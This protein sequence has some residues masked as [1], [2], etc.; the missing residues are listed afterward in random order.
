MIHTDE[1]L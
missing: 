1:M